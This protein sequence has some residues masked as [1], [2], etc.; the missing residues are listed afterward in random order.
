MLAVIFALLINHDQTDKTSGSWDT[1]LE[2]HKQRSPGLVCTTF[3][4]CMNVSGPKRKSKY[5]CRT[6]KPP[7][8]K[9]DIVVDVRLRSLQGVSLHSSTAD[10][11]VSFNNE[12]NADGSWTHDTLFEPRKKAACQDVIKGKPLNTVP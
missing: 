4:P 6:R 10:G 8:R 11:G 2:S 12:N 1:I 5:A 3:N 7:F 9:M